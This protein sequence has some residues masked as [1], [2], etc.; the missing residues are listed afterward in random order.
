MARQTLTLA[1]EDV[2][3]GSLVEN[4]HFGKQKETAYQCSNHMNLYLLSFTEMKGA[5]H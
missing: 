4:K 3:V 2:E 5:F 1:M